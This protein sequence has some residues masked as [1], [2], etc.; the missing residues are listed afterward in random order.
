MRD[1]HLFLGLSVATV[2]NEL[3]GLE[4]VRIAGFGVQ[5]DLSGNVDGVLGV[6]PCVGFEFQVLLAA[7][8]GV[9][10]VSGLKT[11]LL[12]FILKYSFAPSPSVLHFI[13]RQAA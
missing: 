10:V 3:S 13:A 7:S 2:K 11:V 1:G 9:D 12:H 6:K 4:P 8:T 5:Q